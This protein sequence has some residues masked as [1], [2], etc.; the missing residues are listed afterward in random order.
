M[1]V[2]YRFFFLILWHF[3]WNGMFYFF[4]RVD[5]FLWHRWRCCFRKQVL[6]CRGKSTHNTCQR[7][8]FAFTFTHFL[9]EKKKM[10][11]KWKIWLV[12][13]WG[14]Q[15]TG[16]VYQLRSGR[17]THTH[18]ATVLSQRWFLINSFSH[19]ASLHISLLFSPP[20]LPPSPPP[21]SSGV[22]G[23]SMNVLCSLWNKYLRCLYFL[24]RAPGGG[25][26]S[27]CLWYL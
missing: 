26:A 24:L 14:K 3:L 20:S 6:W 22:S 10:R 12:M 9:A 4:A 1:A 16:V 21:L 17:D 5:S 7:A 8:G 11:P 15:K 2:A 18:T 13:T 27:S 19:V 25:E 23:I